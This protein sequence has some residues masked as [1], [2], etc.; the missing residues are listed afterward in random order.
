MEPQEN[1]EQPFSNLAS[2]AIA[3]GRLARR[4]STIA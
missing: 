1:S 4:Y 2:S 3:D